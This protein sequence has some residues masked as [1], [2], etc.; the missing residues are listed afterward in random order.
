MHST[1]RMSTFSKRLLTNDTNL[2]K[3]QGPKINVRS[4]MSSS[5]FG[6]GVSHDSGV[7]CIKT[8]FFSQGSTQAS[9]LHEQEVQSSPVLQD[10]FRKRGDRSFQ[11]G[12]GFFNSQKDKLKIHMRKHMGEQPYQCI[13]CN[14]KFVHN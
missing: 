10:D 2:F 1:N 9:L 8:A 11:R 12:D 4:I 5:Q 14:A 13:P 6:H 3:M 7:V